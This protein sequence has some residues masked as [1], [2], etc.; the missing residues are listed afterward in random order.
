MLA[1]NASGAGLG[2]VVTTYYEGDTPESLGLTKRLPGGVFYGS[3]WTAR[4]RLAG[5]ALWNAL[6]S[7]VLALIQRIR[8][9]EAAL[10]RSRQ[11]V[12]QCTTAVGHCRQ[13]HTG[14]AHRLRRTYV[15]C[16]GTTQLV[17]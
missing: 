7:D 2:Q 9:E 8:Q 17:T 11:R 12:G 10:A 16:R 6:S 1:L 15:P 13:P 4:E 5:L 14:L 3:P